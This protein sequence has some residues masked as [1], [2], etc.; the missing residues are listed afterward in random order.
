MT[1]YV[2]FI[3][4]ASVLGLLLNSLMLRHVGFR[5]APKAIRATESFVSMT[6][7]RVSLNLFTYC[8]RVFDSFLFYINRASLWAFL[9]IKWLKALQKLS[10]SSSK[11][12]ILPM[13]VTLYAIILCPP[14]RVFLN[15]LH[16]RSL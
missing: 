4:S 8:L 2:S 9:C 3:T 1:S 7:S 11:L 14:S 12:Q 6:L 16:Q 5:S 13:G 10:F 15:I